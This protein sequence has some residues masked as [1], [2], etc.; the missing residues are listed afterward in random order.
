VS[1]IWLVRHAPVAASISERGVCY[2]RT[3]VPTSCDAEKAA[4]R[5]LETAGTVPGT[6]RE[7]WSSPAERTRAVASVLSRRLTL[8]AFIDARIAELHF[9]EWEGKTYAAIE[10]AFPE[11]FRRWMS[12]YGTEGPPGG[13]STDELAHRVAEWVRE[14][15][16]EEK[17]IVAVTHAGVI[18]VARSSSSPAASPPDWSRAVEHLVP[19]R[20]PP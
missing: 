14:R 11:R 9:G 10:R 7:V 16:R 19:E 15:R 5:I 13:E 1:A 8:P 17:T 18:R 2:G 6:W 20:L 12:R 4:D 3:D